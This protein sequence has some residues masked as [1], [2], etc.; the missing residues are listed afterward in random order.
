VSL[1]DKLVAQAEA[2]H[3]WIDISGTQLSAQS[4][5]TSALYRRFTPD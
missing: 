3:S 4:G 2:F 1:H 5:G